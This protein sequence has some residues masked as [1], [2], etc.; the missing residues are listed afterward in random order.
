MSGKEE[1]PMQVKTFLMVLVTVVVALLLAPIIIA[2]AITAAGTTGIGSFAGVAAIIG[3]IP[4]G[5]VIL[6]LWYV[7]QKLSNK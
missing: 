2:N 5:F 3:L 4:L 6:A 7:Y 1:L